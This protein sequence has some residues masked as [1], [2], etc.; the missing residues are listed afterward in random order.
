MQQSIYSLFT[1][2]FLLQL[3][4]CQTDAPQQDTPEDVRAAFQLKKEAVAITLRLPAELLPYERAELYTK[5]DAYVQRVQVDIGDRVQKG[6]ELLLL[7][8]PEVKSQTAEA[9][10]R[11]LEAEARYR[12]SEEQYR[13]TLQAAR[14]EGTV[15]AVALS[16]LRGQA[17]AD[18]ARWQ[19]ARLLAQSYREQQEYLRI[20]APFTGVVTSRGVDPGDFASRQNG[21]RLLVVER[22]DLL[23]LRVHVPE[24]YVQALPESEELTFRVDGLRQSEFSARLARKSGSI[25]PQT[26]T[27]T[28][29]YTFDNAEGQILPGMYAT[30]ELKLAREEPS[31]VVPSAAVATTLE[32]KFVIRVRD[33][34]MEWV[35]VRTGISKAGKTEVFGDLEAGDVLLMRA[36]DELKAG[37]KVRIALQD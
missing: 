34:Q 19:A 20:R 37:Q 5:V 15:A 33:T 32:R 6:Q 36:S 12:A 26:R 7:D 25:H 30:V 1:C 2:F 27:E 9:E 23:R 16:T 4:A 22:P 18:S 8:A 3:M 17:Q 21:N 13:R 14:T 24:A 10:A 35:D 11:L 31:F 28:W 29:E